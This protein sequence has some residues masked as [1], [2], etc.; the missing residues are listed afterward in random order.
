MSGEIDLLLRTIAAFD[1]GTTPDRDT[2]P[3]NFVESIAFER[4]TLGS[5]APTSAVDGFGAWF[6]TL[7]AR[8]VRR[9]Q[10][11]FP[12]VNAPGALPDRYRF[13]FSNATGGLLLATGQSPERWRALWNVGNQDAPDRRIWRITFQ[14][15]A[16]PGALLPPPAPIADVTAALVDAI[17]A[18]RD[19]AAGTGLADWEA[20]FAR[21][22]AIAGTPEDAPASEVPG[23]PELPRG[24]RSPEARR[25]LQTARASNAF[26]AMGS[27]N[28]VGVSEADA[29]ERYEHAS[30]GLFVVMLHALV[31]GANT[32]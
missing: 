10:L 13:G 25:L 5:D 1:T 21:A 11:A 24:W 9:L 26:G 27:W 7:R 32:A 29:K 8:G 17:A 6:D 4:W 15:V 12:G 28:D 2:F 3:L 16:E 19:V 14:G 22:Q 23:V 31:A 30:Q 18:V 20:F